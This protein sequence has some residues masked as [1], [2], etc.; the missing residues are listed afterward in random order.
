MKP[1]DQAKTF[2]PLAFTLKRENR[3]ESNDLYTIGTE[4]ENTYVGEYMNSVQNRVNSSL[5]EI[6]AWVMGRQ[7]IIYNLEKIYKLL[8]SHL[9]IEEGWPLLQAVI[10]DSRG[11]KLSIWLS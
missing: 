9:H 10:K 1:S 6:K 11:E 3:A 4:D 7:S 5:Y 2:N 8:W